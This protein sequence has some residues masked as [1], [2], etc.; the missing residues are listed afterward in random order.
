MIDRLGGS[1][2]LLLHAVFGQLERALQLGRLQALDERVLV[3][4]VGQQSRNVA[5]DE[6]SVRVESRSELRS[7]AVRRRR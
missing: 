2:H 3:G 7:R 4:V 5:E 1:Q 6:E